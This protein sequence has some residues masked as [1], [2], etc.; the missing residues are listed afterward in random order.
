MYGDS[1]IKPQPPVQ[2]AYITDALR[3]GNDGGAQTAASLRATANYLYWLCGLFQLQA[4]N[5]ISGPGGGSVSPTPPT[6]TLPNPYDF[7]VDGSSFIPTG[8]T[9]VNIPSFIG[10]NIDFVRNSISQ[11]TTAPPF[12]DTYF[13]WNRVTGDFTLL[14]SGAAIAIAQAGERFRITPIG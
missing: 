4:Q 13:S 12:D 3:W 9:T 10:F 14:A 6:A 1:V 5:I 7:I 2:I 11:Y 8:G